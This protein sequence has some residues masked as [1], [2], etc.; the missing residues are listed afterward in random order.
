MILGSRTGIPAGWFDPTVEVVARTVVPG[1][2]F[3]DFPARPIFAPHLHTAG[4]FFPFAY[5]ERQRDMAL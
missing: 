1:F 3:P 4:M 2:P 5:Q